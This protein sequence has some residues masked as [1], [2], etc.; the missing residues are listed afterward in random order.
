V[1]DLS[2]F[3][4]MDPKFR[5]LGPLE[6]RVIDSTR[7]LTEIVADCEQALAADDLRLYPLTSRTADGT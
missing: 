7:T 4:V 5:D 1:G 3:D 2:G 6:R